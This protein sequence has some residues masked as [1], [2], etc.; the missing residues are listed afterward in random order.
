MQP[1]E[2][3]LD[4]VPNK[5]E[6]SVFR[7]IG[8]ECIVVSVASSVADVNSIFC[9]NETGAVIWDLMDGKR[10]LRDIVSEI[11]GQFETAGKQLETDVISFV[12]DMVEFKL[13]EA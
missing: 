6:N 10:N 7:K 2:V 12:R 3:T 11:G 5:N 4:S 8:D 1:M 9:L 13:I